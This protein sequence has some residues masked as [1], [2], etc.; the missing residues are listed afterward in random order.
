[1]SPTLSLLA[2]IWPDYTEPLVAGIAAFALL[3]WH[4]WEKRRTRKA[5]NLIVM[6]VALVANRLEQ[7]AEKMK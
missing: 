2:F 5:L 3:L 6:G 7:I 1:M 4:A